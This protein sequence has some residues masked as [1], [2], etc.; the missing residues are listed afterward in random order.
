MITSPC[1]WSNWK[2]KR[3][4][5][6]TGDRTSVVPWVWTLGLKQGLPRV[7][8]N[9]Q[10]CLCVGT[11]RATYQELYRYSGCG[12]ATGERWLNRRGRGILLVNGGR[13]P[14][15]KLWLL[16]GWAV[17]AGGVDRHGGRMLDSA[18]WIQ[19][20]RSKRNFPLSLCSTQ[21][22]PKQSSQHQRRDGR[23]VPR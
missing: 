21:L 4:G 2:E 6:I 12:H 17:A 13:P 20:F 14:R 3:Y 19:R 1:H 22:R 16:S 15:S 5:L 10:Q 9:G 11:L 7:D 23:R 18:C 8:L